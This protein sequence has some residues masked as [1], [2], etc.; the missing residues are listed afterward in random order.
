MEAAS[1]VQHVGEQNLCANIN[2][3]LERARTVFAEIEA[4]APSA[5]KWGRRAGESGK[6]AGAAV[7]AVEL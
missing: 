7:A 2:E 5:M 1:F 6:H 3:A 4:K